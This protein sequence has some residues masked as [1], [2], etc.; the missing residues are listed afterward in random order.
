M[1][2][3]I[4]IPPG[5]YDELCKLV[6]QK[7]DVGIFQSSNSSYC[8]QWFCVL[9]KDGKLLQIVQSLE[10]LNKVT[11]TH[12]GIPPFTEQLAEFVGHTCNSMMDLY[13]RY[14]KHMLASSSQD[15]T[16]F[17]MPYGAM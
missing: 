8:S 10:P 5:L 2:R 9:K 6:K 11:I 14:D 13:V 3:N 7:I 15:L 1:E 16:T 4:H 17:Q 12:L